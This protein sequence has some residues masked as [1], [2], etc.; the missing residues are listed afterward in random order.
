M[1]S[2]KKDLLSADPQ[3]VSSAEQE[4]PEDKASPRWPIGFKLII[5]LL[6]IV[7]FIVALFYLK[8]YVGL[9]LIGFL[10]AFLLKPTIRRLSYKL[11]LSWGLSVAIIY[12][13][14]LLVILG[15]IAG[16]G[17][18]LIN[19]AENIFKLIN[20]N[21]GGLN[22]LAA[23]WAG[24]FVFIGPYNFQIP[25]INTELV[26]KELLNRMQSL[27]GTAGTAVT[28]TVGFVGSTIFKLLIVYVLSLFLVG[29]GK[30]RSNPSETL[31][32][33]GYAYDFRKFT[34][35]VNRIWNAFIRGQFTV[36]AFTIGFYSLMLAILGFPY[37]LGLALVAGLGRLVP[38]LGAWITWI[39]FGTAALVLR[40]TPFGL[41]PL[42]YMLIVLAIALVIDQYIDNGLQPRVIGN[43]LSVHPA[44]IM[45]SALV[46]AQLFGLLGLILNAP[47]LAT[48]KLASHYVIQKLMDKD[49]WEGMEYLDRTKTKSFLRFKKL[50]RGFSKA[51]LY[52]FNSLKNWI[53]HLKNI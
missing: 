37:F 24:K 7:G 36:I 2:E 53:K 51:I 39:T 33:T 11:K 52:T 27:V 5:A 25:V 1:S 18:F 28:K 21:L 17:S 48:A 43:A 46:S 8:E 49:P 12:F 29:D 35:E 41:Q 50:T 3:K 32:A 42:T 10:I 13:L 40:P 19:Q 6:L 15:A 30:K 47:I 14:F 9:L 31:V 38:Y 22:D 44:A 16:G 4:K 20:D 34:L 45:I 26:S 23:K